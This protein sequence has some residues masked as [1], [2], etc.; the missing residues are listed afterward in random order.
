MGVGLT[1]T[2]AAAAGLGV[3]P[4]VWIAVAI[5]GGLSFVT[6]A[7][8]FVVGPS[9]GLSGRARSDAAPRR[10]HPG[11]PWKR[12]AEL[13]VATVGLIALLG[14]GVV[15][16]TRVDL[17]PSRGAVIVCI[18]SSGSTSAA[19]ASYL[20]DL[21]NVVLQAALR[22]QRLYVADCGPNATGEVNWPVQRKFGTDHEAPARTIA[23]LEAEEVFNRGVRGLVEAAPEAR[24]MSLGEVLGVMALQ[25]GQAGGSCTLYLFTDAE[26][27]DGQIQ[28]R[29][30]LS[31]AE[32]RN[33]L[34]T[35]LPQ[36]RDLDGSQVN[37]VGVGL[38]TS[39]GGVRLGEAREI[40][41]QLVEGAGGEMGAWTAR[42]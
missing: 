40:A 29:D 7:V 10:W 19:R 25:C 17:S 5:A 31:E 30:G 16:A 42:L 36:L 28:L 33:Y 27:S 14:G 21:K 1:L 34:K 6:A 9:K 18:D 22:R 15:I 23:Y 35:H 39:I 37:F 11:S 32:R 41:S 2:T 8:L 24:G 26:W 3:S 38:G 20:S 13:V 12:S 4:G